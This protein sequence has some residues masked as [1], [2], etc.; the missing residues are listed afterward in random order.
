MIS[1]EA[2]KF[3]ASVIIMLMVCCKYDILLLLS[4]KAV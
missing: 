3:L 4:P 2:N 1:N